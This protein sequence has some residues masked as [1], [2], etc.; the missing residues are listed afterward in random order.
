LLCEWLVLGIFC[1]NRLSTGQQGY[2]GLKDDILPACGRENS[3][4]KNKDI[5]FQQEFSFLFPLEKKSL[6]GK[7]G[8]FDSNMIFPVSGKYQD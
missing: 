6:P 5:H 8:E 2:S 7:W 1:I 4:H 3:C